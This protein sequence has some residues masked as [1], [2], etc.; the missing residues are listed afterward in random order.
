MR[1]SST[2]PSSVILS[3]TKYFEKMK[4]DAQ[5]VPKQATA[6]RNYVINPH[7]YIISIN[8]NKPTGVDHRT[9]LHLPSRIFWSNSSDAHQVVEI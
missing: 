5:K 8:F 3:Q 4:S 2:E 1:V 7:N 9:W 6:K